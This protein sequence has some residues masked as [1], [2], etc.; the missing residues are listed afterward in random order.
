MN[1]PSRRNRSRGHRLTI[2]RLLAA[3]A[4]GF[5]LFSVLLVLPWRWL[6]P[7]TSS[8]MLQERLLR[9]IEPLH[10]EWQPLAA[11]SPHLAIAVI[12][13]EDQKFP[14]HFGFDL[15]SI[16]KAFRERNRRVRGASTISQQVAKNLF[17]WPQQ[18]LFRKAVEA[19]L[20]LCIEALWPKRRILEVYLN[21]AE[22]AP[23]VFGAQ[24]AAR[25]HFRTTA[26][27][28]DLHQATLLAAVLPSPKRMSARHPSQYVHRRAMEIE[29]F[30][31]QLGG[32]RYLEKIR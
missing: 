9:D 25:H 32:T 12:A 18:S 30:V 15:D 4:L 7:P 29:T 13:S 10:Y 23:G 19:W 26:A 27:R 3:A 31:R 8:Y 28:L 5:A 20:T 6:P 24:A 14:D 16:S 1:R 22:F 11:I 21:V 2:G 17:L